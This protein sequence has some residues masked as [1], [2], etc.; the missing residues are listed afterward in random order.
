[1][2]FLK[3]INLFST[4]CFLVILITFSIPGWWLT[5]V[6]MLLTLKNEDKL[7][8]LEKGCYHQQ[9]WGPTSMR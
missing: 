7:E 1:M 6:L 5:A 4:Y 2:N 3:S 8:V 9:A